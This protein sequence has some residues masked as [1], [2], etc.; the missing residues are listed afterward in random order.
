MKNGR[1]W[2]CIALFLGAAPA[3]ADI[4]TYPSYADWASVVSGLTTV[5]IPDPASVILTVGT[6]DA[7]VTYSGV[8]FSQIGALDEDARL[9][10]IGSNVFG[11]PTALVS[12]QGIG[13]PSD[14][15][16]TLPTPV[17][18]FALNYGTFDGAPVSFVLSNGDSITQPST[19]SGYSTV[20][21]FAITDNKP[22][23]SVLM[24]TPNDIVL[25]ASD[26]AYGNAAPEPRLFGLIA[27]AM[28]GLFL[29]RATSRRPA[30]LLK[31]PED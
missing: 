17:K 28:G 24:T 3:F 31:P 23:S 19:G 26:V 14:I 11:N 25:N 16:I 9:F 4:S 20:D 22:F 10:V 12:S 1:L 13:Q 6:G 21:L 8:T 29:R 15:L 7:S 30:L 18:S 5:T 27:L 2:I